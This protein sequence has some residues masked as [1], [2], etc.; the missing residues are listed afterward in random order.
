MMCMNTNFVLQKSMHIKLN[1][2]SMP[3]NF[4]LFKAT[5]LIFTFMKQAKINSTLTKLKIQIVF[6]L[7]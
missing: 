1:N 3:V 4:Y 2:D 5:I 7:G 6:L